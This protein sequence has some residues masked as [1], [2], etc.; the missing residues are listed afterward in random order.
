MAKF[1]HRRPGSRAVRQVTPV[2]FLGAVTAF[3]LISGLLGILLAGVLLPVA[4]A[5]GATV[6][7]LPESFEELPSSISLVTPS[8]ESRMLDAGGNEIARFYSTRRIVVNSDQM[9]Q[10]VKDAIVAIEDHRFFSHHGVDPDGLARAFVNNLG[11]STTQGA[12]TLT[13]Q[14][15]KNMLL[16]QGI[17]EGDQDLI[18]AAQAQSVQRKLREARYAMALESKMTKDQILTGY[19]NV[20]PFG[21]NI[22]GVEAASRAYFSV[23]A[24]ELTVGQ[25]AL[26][27]GLVQS[28]VEYDPL[29]YP[30]A[31]QERRDTVLQKMYEYDYI[32]WDQYMEAKSVSVADMLNPENRKEGCEGATDNMGYFCRYVEESFLADSAFGETRQ[33][34]QHLL[35]TGG[36]V[37]RTT[38]DRTLQQYA[39]TAVT[40]RVP[41][42]DND[43]NDT[44][45][46]AL[47]SVVPQTGY[48]VSMAQNTNF[49]PA[50]DNRTT[51]VSYNAYADHGGG[52]GFQPGS[53]FKV[54]T[55]AEW[56]R[57]GRFAYET[58]GGSKRDYN[59]GSF[60][61]DGAVYP[62][63]PWHV[64]D[65]A[66][67]D[68]PQTVLNTMMQS[69]N[70]GI[71]SMATKVDYCQIFN[72]ATDLG[73][74]KEDG[75][76]FGPE[77]PSQLIGGAD[78]V[79]PLLMASAYS[80]FANGGV[81]CAPMSIVEVADR[82]GNVIKSYAPSCNQAMDQQVS[83][84]VATVLKKVAANYPYVTVDHPVAAKS[85]TT[86]DNTN[87]WM[88]G[89]SPQ[90]ATAAW[91][92]FASN[93][94][95]GIQDM[96][97]NGTYYEAIYGGDFAAPM[98]SEY[99]QN[100]TSGM[101]RI[102][103]PEVFIGNRPVTPAPKQATAP[104]AGNTN[105][106]G[107][108][109]ANQNN[110]TDQ[111]NNNG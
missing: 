108:G 107:N 8:E 27:A 104:A 51:Y 28:P 22:Y 35:D 32:T 58:V 81:R 46:T 49:G 69:I 62:T 19:L 111:G 54:F 41:I 70:Q 44:V 48:I 78:T 10:S 91:A 55:L 83:D 39:F 75:T 79:S 1:S 60:S 99:M 68:G 3:A 73:I 67:K 109:N 36:L 80:A 34:R 26:L 15:V 42:Y 86:E 97:I 89:F 47:V 53:T 18:D 101:E 100:A 92:G 25:A 21:P 72:R 5:A 24:S 31:A 45:D 95:R 14:F 52:I 88:V 82:D 12:S 87:V 77:N 56:F 7:A 106:A 6:R 103:I 13:Q 30:D 105:T 37:I 85:G 40:N 29:Q 74:V 66:G 50:T 4:G 84:K 110:T 90:L 65:L 20:A 17:Q 102:D 2:Q 38:I 9:S 98:W 23:S 93:S 71:A 59:S 43:G 63:G 33:D 64:G 16:E 96:Y 61:C 57:E 11:G 94:S 76:P